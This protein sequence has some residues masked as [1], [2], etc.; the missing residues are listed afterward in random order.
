VSSQ[1]KVDTG[2]RSGGRW[3]AGCLGAVLR[4]VLA[5]A[6][7]VAIW[8]DASH[9]RRLTAVLGQAAGHVT[10]RAAPYLPGPVF[11]FVCLVLGTGLMLAA[12]RHDSKRR[13]K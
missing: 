8:W 2:R 3:A 7:C 13:R 4:L 10:Q 5:T 12:I 9:G 11:R 1:G 6:A